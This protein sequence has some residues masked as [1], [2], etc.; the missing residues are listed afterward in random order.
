MLSR[1]MLAAHQTR[2]TSSVNIHSGMSC[3]PTIGETL[4]QL[5]AYPFLRESLRGREILMGE[6]L[7]FAG[8]SVIVKLCA[9]LYF[10]R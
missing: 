7:S 8:L 1:A 6:D 10:T 3:S 2:F 5:T 9:L 4:Q